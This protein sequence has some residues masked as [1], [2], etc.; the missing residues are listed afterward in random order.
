MECLFF[1]REIIIL[2][3]KKDIRCIKVFA[4][5][6]SGLGYLRG[7]MALKGFRAGKTLD[8]KKKFGKQEKGLGSYSIYVLKSCGARY[9]LA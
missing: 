4:G 3:L 7:A 6:D 2:S 9:L 8:L 5:P 1:C